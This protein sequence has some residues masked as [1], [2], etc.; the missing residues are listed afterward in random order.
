VNLLAASLPQA[1]ANFT[2]DAANEPIQVTRSNGVSSQYTYD[3]AG[4]LVSITHSGGQGIQIPLGYSNDAANDRL[5]YTTDVVEP[6]AVNNTFDAGG[7]LVQSGSSTYT[8][9]DN[10][11]LT[12]A[13]DSTGTTTYTWDSRNRLQSV[14]APNGQKTTLVYDFAGNLISQRDSGPTLN[15]T[16][17]FVLDRTNTAYIGRSNGDNLLVLAG[18]ALDQHLAVVHTNGQ[19][20]YGLPDAS[21]S[22]IATADQAGKAVSSFS[23]EPFGKTTTASSYP[24]QFTGR[25]PLTG[26]LYYYRARCFESRLGRFISEDPIAVSRGGR[27]YV[28]VG[29]SPYVHSDPKGLQ[30]EDFAECA[31]R[32]I[33][34]N[35]IENPL[36]ESAEYVGL[37]LKALG[38]GRAA[39]GVAAAGVACA[40]YNA[41]TYIACAYYCPEEPPTP[42]CSE[43]GRAFDLWVPCNPDPVCPVPN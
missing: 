17:S 11:N 39:V 23:Y 13:T 2:Y 25:M 16:Q 15:L 8:Y 5:L 34:A 36:C 21:R 35:A 4:R 26:S 10:G 30:D 43:E 22:T 3:S 33:R 19:V 1:A 20:E 18:R 28:Y 29:N 37:L 24:F 41:A 7:R 38:K 12:S 27:A 31:E 42:D 9:D 32:C 40:V 6:P 14:F